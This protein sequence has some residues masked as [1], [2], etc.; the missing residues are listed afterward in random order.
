ME[1]TKTPRR[2]LCIA[3]AAGVVGGFVVGSIFGYFAH[4]LNTIPNTSNV[5]L[6]YVIP[7][8]L[9]IKVQDANLDGTPEATTVIYED[10][11]K[12]KTAYLFKLIKENVYEDGAITPTIKTRPAVVPFELKEKR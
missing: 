3:L 1:N 6:G 5:A 2:P 12:Q 10:E 7:S 4:S 9:E 8:N 11:N